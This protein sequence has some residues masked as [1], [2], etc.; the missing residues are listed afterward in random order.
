V[1]VVGR[2]ISCR[3]SA[4]ASSAKSADSVEYLRAKYSKS[5]TLTMNSSEE[6]S[7]NKEIDKQSCNS[8][9]RSVDSGLYEDVFELNKDDSFSLTTKKGRG[10]AVSKSDSGVV[11]DINENYTIQSEQ[12]IE[13]AI[14][15][16]VEQ[17]CLCHRCDNSQLDNAISKEQVI[18][19]CKK[20]H[21]KQIE[22]KEAIVELIQTEINYGQD[23]RILKEEFFAPIKSGGILSNENV[24]AVF[25][26]LQELIDVNSK[27][28]ITL[29]D[30]LEECI[31]RNDQELESLQVGR[32]F[33]ENVEFFQAYEVFCTKQRQ[34]S[35]LVESLQKKSELL[36]I[37]LQVSCKQNSKLRKMDLKSFLTMPVQ[38]IMKYPLLLTR[39][40]RVT[41]RQNSDREALIQARRKIEE[42]ITKINEI[43]SGRPSKLRKSKSTSALNQT[44]SKG[45]HLLRLVAEIL[46]WKLEETQI[47]LSDA[48]EVSFCVDIRS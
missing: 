36:R 25:L 17:E 45:N 22:R 18:E 44:Q 3:R 33:L 14:Q 19:I 29:Q 46:E 15:E 16:N 35:E 32:V 11:K 24:S 21:K 34:A 39:I 1:S 40:Y 12:D 47:V 43:A 27:L 23:L 2:G 4:S 48:F 37:F 31:T 26:N 5:P 38:R 6:E 28:C 13:E 8:S 42:Q 7:N 20:C 41:P 10:S 9:S 30:D